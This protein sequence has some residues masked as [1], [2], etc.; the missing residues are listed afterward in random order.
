MITPCK[1]ATHVLGITDTTTF[2]RSS[3]VHIRYRHKAVA[4]SFACSCHR[5]I[6]TGLDVPHLDFKQL[7]IG[8]SAF[9]IPHA[10]HVTDESGL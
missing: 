6:V 5:E 8:Q 7:A 9:G 1:F 10:E 4:A 2:P 3:G